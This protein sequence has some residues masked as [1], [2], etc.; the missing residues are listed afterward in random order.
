[1]GRHV[2]VSPEMFSLV[3]LLDFGIV[4]QLKHIQLFNSVRKYFVTS[5]LL[6]RHP[7]VKFVNDSWF[8][9]DIVHCFIYSVF[10][11][12]LVPSPILINLL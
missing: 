12:N 10:S 11:Y 2:Q 6:N 8:S 7:V 3:P 4:Q 1:M 5:A 9:I